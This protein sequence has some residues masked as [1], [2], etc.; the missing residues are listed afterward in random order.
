MGPR[1]TVTK[2]TKQWLGQP[3]EN[4]DRPHSLWLVP[5]SKFLQN[6]N[7]CVCVVALP[8]FAGNTFQDLPRRLG[9]TTDNTERYIRV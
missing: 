3:Q 2:V 6:Q 9:E 1:E 4:H 8:V 5:Y 7:V